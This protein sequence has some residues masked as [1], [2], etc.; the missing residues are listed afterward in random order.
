MAVSAALGWFGWR[1]LNQQRAIDEQ[2]VREQLESSADALA[3]GIRGRLAEAGE[4]LRGWLSSPTMSA[5]AT[6][7]AVVIAIGTV[8]VG[9]SPTPEDIVV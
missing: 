9:I 6:D 1:L 4:R 8:P 3:G 5:P 2:R 7:H